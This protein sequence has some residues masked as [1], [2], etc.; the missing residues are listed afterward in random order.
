MKSEFTLA[1][2]AAAQ[3]MD[4]HGQQISVAVYQH[5]QDTIVHALH[6]LADLIAASEF[7]Y[8]TDWIQ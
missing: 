5:G 2:R 1:A 6:A 4:A 8:Q 3:V 7:T